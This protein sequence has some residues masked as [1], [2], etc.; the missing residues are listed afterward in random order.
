MDQQ[1]PSQSVL[2]VDLGG[3]HLRAALVQRTGAISLQLK[4]DTPKGD[5]VDSLVDA[6]TAA[7]R[8]LDA[9]VEDD[10]VS[11]AIMVPGRVDLARMNVVQAPNLPCL[12]NFP[13]KQVLEEKLLVPV[14]LENDANAAAVGEMWMGAARGARNVICITLGT[15][16]GGGI[17]LDGKLWRGTDGSAGEIG[18]TT[19]DPFGGPPCKCGNTGCL[20]MFASATAIVRM[21]KELLP[22]YPNSVLHNQCVTAAKVYDAGQQGDELATE[23]FRTMGRYL[24]VGLANLINIL[25]PE[26]IVI[27]GGVADGW[28][29][30]EA[31]MHEQIRQRAFPSLVKHVKIKPAECGD[32]A[33]LLG[34]AK[35]AF[36]K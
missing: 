7:A 19:V 30:F 17:I 8:E 14:L 20:E 10:L 22:H 29:L 36:D 35:L 13:L 21:T 23:A 6:L 26:V 16:V 31:D 33:G 3:T 28:T 5:D 1:S 12:D 15:G 2:A 27:G 32:N 24:G 18:H 11:A 25:G 4:H 34:A 9:R